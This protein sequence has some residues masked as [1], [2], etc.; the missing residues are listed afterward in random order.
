MRNRAGW[1]ALAVL[2]A[3]TLLMVFFV[4]PRI[5]PETT[6]VADSINRAGETVS[7]AVRQ[8]AA[9]APA[10]KQAAAPEAKVSQ[11]NS[12]ESPQLPAPEPVTPAFDV[13]RVEPDGSAVIA[14]R[15]EPGATIE[16]NSNEAAIA[17]AK[18]GPSGDFA[19][20]LDQPLP[21]G[22]HQLVLRATTEDGRT[23]VSEETATVSVPTTKDGKL[24]AMVTKPGKASRLV[25][26]PAAARQP[27]EGQEVLG[28]NASTS[29]EATAP[30]LPDGASDII[31]A[32]PP[33][34]V[35]PTPSTPATTSAELQVT[36]VELEGD[37]IFIAGTAPAGASLVGFAG[38]HPVGRS[39][40]SQDGHFVI[41]GT[42]ALEVGEHVIGVEMLDSNGKTAIRVA[43]PF[44]RPAGE[45]VAAVAGPQAISSPPPLDGGSF[46][47]LRDDAA[48]AFGL[49]RGLYE[50][51]KEP[52]SEE[53]AA[54]R[55][56]TG[57][58][59]R[60]LSEYRLPA[61]TTSSA[62]AIVDQTVKEAANA[63][64]E[65]EELPAEPKAVGEELD[66]LAAAVERVLRPTDVE[67]KPADVET[68]QQGEATGPK[69]IEQAPLTQ[70]RSSVIIR[71]G[72]TLWQI[73]RRVYGQGVRYTTIYLAN[74]DQ[75]SNPD[76]IEPGQIFGVPDEALP[77]AEE[78][79]RKRLQKLT[80]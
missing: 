48:R 17:S 18:V 19:I 53:L 16:I 80:R 36:A 3:A 66:E 65:I 1:L 41:E 60:S 67:P 42:R 26:I 79:H 24:L 47:K 77:D 28:A 29:A 52:T 56:A 61:G 50:G 78:L 73:S 14:G 13:L 27:A 31:A 37:R 12:Q 11:G 8:E 23:V 76:L 45:Q 57:I 43:V 2:V 34:A 5:S 63:L 20:A 75:I 39:K 59:L 68:A 46:A 21:A 38:E 33:M 74:E 7:E 22:D 15:A 69:T 6:R 62:Q 44:N 40:A 35:D 10:S 51:G 4:L 64:A 25:N 70:A 54:A 72:D 58:A 49:L 71:R 30:A 55:S 32:A 9:P